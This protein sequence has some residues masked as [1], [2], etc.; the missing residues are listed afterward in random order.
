MEMS[1]LASRPVDFTYGKEPRYR[2]NGWLSGP[3]SRSSSFGK[4]KYLLLF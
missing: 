4:D 2:L 3:Q 1:D